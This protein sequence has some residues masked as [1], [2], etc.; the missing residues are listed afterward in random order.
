MHYN[1]FGRVVTPGQ[2]EF[3]QDRGQPGVEALGLATPVVSEKFGGL[4]TSIGWLG[5]LSVEKTIGRRSRQ[6]SGGCSVGVEDL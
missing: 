6:W 3:V 5:V 4:E 2:G 1:K